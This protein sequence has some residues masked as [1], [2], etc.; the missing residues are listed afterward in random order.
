MRKFS[1]P[2]T[3][4]FEAMNDARGIEQ[5]HNRLNTGHYQNVFKDYRKEEFIK[6]L[7]NLNLCAYDIKVWSSKML[8]KLKEEK[9]Y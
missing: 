8:V 1:P 9:N 5:I 3:S 6:F 4:Y 2:S 7:E